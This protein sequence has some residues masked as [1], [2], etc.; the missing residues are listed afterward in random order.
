MTRRIAMKRTAI[1]AFATALLLVLVSTRV[2]GE[3][4]ETIINNG[5]SQNRVDVAIL[6]DGY[7]AAQAQQYKTDVQTFMAQV[8]NT[9]PLR[10]YQRYFNVH[11]IDIVS[12]QS[13]ADHPE[14][15]T[16]VD[17]ALDATYNCNG[18]QRLICVDQNK[19]NTV[20]ANTLGATQHDVVLVIVNDPVYGGS[21]GAIAV[22][23]TNA[24]AVELIL[25]E[26]GHSFGLLTDEYGGPP[27]PVC[28][29]S[30]EPAAA[31]A[32]RHDRWGP[33]PLGGC[34]LL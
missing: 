8:F 21:G 32:A 28:D 15:G 22:A 19:V 18:I 23:S 34:G 33:G 7:T 31:N 17:T 6:G 3:P 29:T 10:E 25:H 13:G 2:Q 4:F 9:E 16:A 12:N 30:V 1:K 14:N 11:R 20:I 24:K 26:E 5:N 27:P